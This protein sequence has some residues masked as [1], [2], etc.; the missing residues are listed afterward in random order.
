MNPISPFLPAHP[1]DA[2]WT[3]FLE[4]VA[5]GFDCITG[6]LHR[7]DPQ[8]Q[9]LKLVAHR[10]IPPQ[11]MPVIQSIPLGKGI[12]GAAAERREPI[13]MCNL[14]TD[15]SGVAKPGAKQTQVQGTLAVPVMDGDRLCGTLGIGKVVP[16]EFTAD[17]KARL[18]AIAAE[19]AARLA[20]D[21]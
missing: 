8:D 7:F 19:V 1:S 6:T 11:L 2:D 21:R 5:S 17:E 9:H 4:S 12:A 20:P 3:Q 16:Y 10:G 13:E 18:L 14:Q 15:T